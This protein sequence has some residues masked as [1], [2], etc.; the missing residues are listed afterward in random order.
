MVPAY[1]RDDKFCCYTALRGILNVEKPKNTPICV[2]TD[3]EEVGFMGN[4]GM[5]SKAFENFVIKLLDK[6]GQNSINALEKVFEKSEVISADVT[7]AFDPSF[8][9]VFEANNDAYLG[10]GVAFAKYVGARGKAGASE[11][12]AEFVA[13][14]RRIFKEAGAKYQ[15]AELGKVDEGGGRNYSTYIRK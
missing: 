4:T 15:A 11:A 12:S 8:S 7:A 13:K 5:E 3:R 10:R 6:T 9:D 2:L 14:T 1:G